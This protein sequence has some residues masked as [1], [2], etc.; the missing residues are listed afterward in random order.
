MLGRVRTGLRIPYALNT[1][2]TLEARRQGMS[3]NA[4]ILTILQ[5][6]AKKQVNEQ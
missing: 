4:L 3:K 6:W 2:L 1:W 5:N